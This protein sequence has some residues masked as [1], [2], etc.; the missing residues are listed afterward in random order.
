MST[1]ILIESMLAS[2]RDLAAAKDFPDVYVMTAAAE[3]RLRDRIP[4][5]SSKP[6]ELNSV[7]GIPFESRPTIQLAL[8]RIAELRKAGK[9]VVLLCGDE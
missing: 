3:Q 6:I 5:L 4:V 2:A 7:Y 8:Q 1:G 9:E